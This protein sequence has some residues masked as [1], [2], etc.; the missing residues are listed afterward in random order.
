[1]CV[2]IFKKDRVKNSFPS[3]TARRKEPVKKIYE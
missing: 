3:P 2:S 1:M